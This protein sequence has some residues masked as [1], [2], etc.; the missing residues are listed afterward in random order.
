MALVQHRLGIQAARVLNDDVFPL[1][2]VLWID[3]PL[4]AAA[5]IA[6]LASARR[7]ISLVDWASFELM[8]A[9]GLQHVF[10]FDEHFGEQGFTL[11]PGTT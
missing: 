3:K 1:V 5:M 10:A 7:D 8:R 6:C 4:H 2:N 9:Q 11:M